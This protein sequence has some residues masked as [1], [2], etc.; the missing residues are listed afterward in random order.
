MAQTIVRFT[1]ADGGQIVGHAVGPDHGPCVL[2]AHGGGQTKRTWAKTLDQL[3]E[4]GYRAV[5]IDLRGHG[6]SDW[7]QNGAY[8]TTDF[9]ADLLSVCDRLGVRP[10]LVGASLGGLAGLLAEGQLRP[11]SLASLTLVDIAPNVSSAGVDRIVGFMQKHMDTGFA[12]LDEA[13]EVIAAYTPNRARR[14]PSD[15]LQHYLRLGPDQRY[16]WH[17][18]PA[19]I[20]NVHVQIQS[21]TER[22]VLMDA[23]V[24]A[25]NLPVHLIRG[26]TSDLLTQDAA[27]AF[28]Q[29]VPGLVYSDIEGA[30]HMV[31]GDRND[32]FSGAIL[33]FLNQQPSNIAQA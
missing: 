25:L 31:V 4:A 21:S 10:H 15:G 29:S 24:A 17:W 18:D 11:G 12:S 16:R 6:E 13:A 20:S 5:A 28:R 9:A 22:A 1:G 8:D 2:L 33:Q 14:G 27:D 19:F 26:A 23:A 30:G 3:A 32:A 7:A